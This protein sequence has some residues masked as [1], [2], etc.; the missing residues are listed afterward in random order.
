MYGRLTTLQRL[1]HAACGITQREEVLQITWWSDSGAIHQQTIVSLKF[2]TALGCWY[3]FALIALDGISC[4][5]FGKLSLS[6]TGS[7]LWNSPKRTRTGQTN[8]NGHGQTAFHG[9]HH[10]LIFAL[11]FEIIFK[12][13]FSTSSGGVCCTSDKLTIE[14]FASDVCRVS[15]PTCCPIIP[16]CARRSVAS[17]E[18]NGSSAASSG[19]CCEWEKQIPYKTWIQIH[20]DKYTIVMCTCWE[21][22]WNFRVFFQPVLWRLF[23]F[24]CLSHVFC[25]RIFVYK[26]C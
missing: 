12:T 16:Q 11:F 7:K 13:Q 24:F 18:R 20:K 23:L 21:P 5:R 15:L 9:G 1:L 2:H 3:R 19:L 14:Q 26:F 25:I 4:N 6:Q 10:F 17:V 8:H 22:N